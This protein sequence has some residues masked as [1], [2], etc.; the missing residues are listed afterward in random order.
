MLKKQGKD[1][2]QFFL[3]KVAQLNRIPASAKRTILAGIYSA[4]LAVFVEDTSED[5]AETRAFLD[6]RIEGVMKFEKA[7]AKWLGGEREHFD[8]VRFLGRLRY[9]AK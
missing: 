3:Q 5:K 8:L 2:P 1:T 9:P 6:R 4:T 7:K